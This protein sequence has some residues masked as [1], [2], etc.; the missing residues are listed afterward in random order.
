MFPRIV[1]V[2]CRAGR[3]PRKEGEPLNNLH[4]RLEVES[5]LSAGDRFL[6]SGDLTSA[7]KQYY[8][9]IPELHQRSQS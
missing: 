7:W 9:T 8:Q 5:K 1:C 3:G 6:R 2:R 4:K